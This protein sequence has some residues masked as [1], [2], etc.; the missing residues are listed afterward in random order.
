MNEKRNKSAGPLVLSSTDTTDQKVV[1]IF[2]SN[3][4]QES[5]QFSFPKYKTISLILKI[6]FD[7]L[8]SPASLTGVIK[9]AAL[10]STAGTETPTLDYPPVLLCVSMWGTCVWVYCRMQV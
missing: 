4:L 7:L 6:A 9:L 8:A 10:F 1:L 2:S 3:T 5:E